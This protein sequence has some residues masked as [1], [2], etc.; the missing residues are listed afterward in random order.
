MNKVLVVI[1]ALF[2][3]VATQAQPVEKIVS[4]FE[5]ETANVQVKTVGEN[6]TLYFFDGHL[7]VLEKI[8][9]VSYDLYLDRHFVGGIDTTSTWAIEQGV[10]AP[11]TLSNVAHI[12]TGQNREILELLILT[13]LE[14]FPQTIDLSAVPEH[15]MEFAAFGMS[16]FFYF[17]TLLNSTEL[18]L[19]VPNLIT[20]MWCER[21]GGEWQEID[22]S[23]YR[24][25]RHIEGM[26]Q[27]F[28]E[29]YKETPEKNESYQKKLEEIASLI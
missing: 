23:M 26:I 29:S 20:E 14:N 22:P 19:W 4:L 16:Q 3:A 1:V 11:A 9:S 12:K 7:V 24:I 15:Q 13:T 25:K 18:T 5:T 10:F 2:I 27:I 28:G 8:G 17:I 21:M 6:F